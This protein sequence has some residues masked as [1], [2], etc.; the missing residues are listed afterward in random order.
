MVLTP[1]DRNS[2]TWDRIAAHIAA[3]IQELRVEND[4]F[5]DHEVTTKRR[6]RVAELKELLRLGDQPQPRE[7]GQ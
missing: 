5:S 7:P 3:R 6:G 4:S 2:K 1:D